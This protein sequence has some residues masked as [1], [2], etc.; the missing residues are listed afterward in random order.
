MFFPFLEKVWGNILPCMAL[1]VLVVSPVWA[2]PDPGRVDSYGRLI[3]RKKQ[4]VQILLPDKN[5]IQLPGRADN[6][7]QRNRLRALEPTR[8]IRHIL[9]DGKVVFQNGRSAT[10]R[11]CFFPK[12]SAIQTTPVWLE[13]EARLANQSVRLVFEEETRNASGELCAYMFLADGRLLNEELLKE[14][15]CLLDTRTTLSPQY[16]ERFKRAAEQGKKNRQQ[17]RHADQPPEDREL[18]K[19]SR[20][21]S[22]ITAGNAALDRAQR[23]GENQFPRSDLPSGHGNQPP[24]P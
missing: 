23:P 10:M 15:L 1:L 14:G 2:E 9:P 21:F 12:G 22:G 17:L 19:Y 13:W 6:F 3:N 24:H 8:T 7:Q 5:L 16:T 4:S 11:G 20:G 18:S